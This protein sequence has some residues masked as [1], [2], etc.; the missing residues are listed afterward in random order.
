M[1]NTKEVF[2][3]LK[4]HD[5]NKP[6]IAINLPTKEEIIA[7]TLGLIPGYRALKNMYENPEGP[8][9]ET[10]DLAAE[11]I[12]PLYGSLIKPAFKGEDIDTEQALKEAAIFGIPIPYTKFPKGHPK[13]GE[14]I[15]NNLKEGLGR[16]YRNL[17]YGL[18]TGRNKV[19][20]E[21]EINRLK[22]QRDVRTG[23][24][25]RARV[26]ATHDAV[27]LVD[28]PAGPYQR[29]NTGANISSVGAQANGNN[30]V[31]MTRRSGGL[32]GSQAWQGDMYPPGRYLAK[33]ESEYGPFQWENDF[34]RKLNDGIR[35]NEYK[36]EYLINKTR[37]PKTGPR[38][39]VIPKEDIADIAIAQGRPDIAERVMNDNSPRISINNNPKFNSY[40]SSQSPSMGIPDNAK[41]K[42]VGNR[43]LE[44]E[45][46]ENF[47]VLPEEDAIRYKFA[48]YYGVPDLYNDWKANPDYWNDFKLKTID[49][50]SNRIQSNNIYHKRAGWSK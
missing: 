50:R 28:V 35:E 19:Y 5:P 36:W 27:P 16:N 25:S 13:A 26:N 39:G 9:T 34:T 12:I 17:K 10:L 8:F 42:D 45:L 38:K 32:E 46:R 23:L 1:A 30:T 29:T 24:S 2:G 44:K 31:H 40:A 15:P 14:P 21:D 37:L 7:A 43:Q 4:P 20:T 11:D 6:M 47:A 33:F 22:S 18:K 3:Q 41:W 49:N 48:E